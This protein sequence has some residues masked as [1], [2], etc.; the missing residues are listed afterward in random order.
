MVVEDPS[1]YFPAQ[2]KNVDRPEGS[3]LPPSRSSTANRRV[4]GRGWSGV[5]ERQRAQH[6]PHAT[7]VPPHTTEQ[8][9]SATNATLVKSLESITNVLAMHCTLVLPLMVAGD[10]PDDQ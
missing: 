3:K 4:A 8:S 5:I 6:P 2:V 7:S 1:K 9:T 10:H